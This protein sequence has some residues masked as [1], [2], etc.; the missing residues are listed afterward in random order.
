MGKS[1]IIAVIR[2]VRPFG[3]VLY[4]NLTGFVA[5]TVVHMRNLRLVM[6][7]SNLGAGKHPSPI[8]QLIVLKIPY[9]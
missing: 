8:D 7:M 9:K 4:A 5:K 6:T 1:S 2:N 3:R